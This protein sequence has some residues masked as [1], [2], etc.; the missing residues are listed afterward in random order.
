MT[1][2]DVGRQAEGE[3]EPAAPPTP[4]IASGD[5]AAAGSAETQFDAEDLANKVM[6]RIDAILDDKV[7]ARVKSIKDKRLAK[8]AKAD[9]ILE[10]VELAGGDKAKIQDALAQSELLNRLDAIEER[11]GSEGAVGAATRR[12]DPDDAAKILQKYDIPF[13]DPEV[14]AWASKQSFTSEQQA[15]AALEALGTKRAKQGNVT[16]AATVGTG[17]QPAP[18]GETDDELLERI[19]GLLRHPLQNVEERKAAI[20]EAKKR[21]LMK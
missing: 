15:L 19:E 16:Q 18:A 4:A 7:D 14:E 2:E 6:E 17:A 20:A 5:S 9:E 21:E 1:E 3:Q 13:D 11:L 8:L 12:A 10:F